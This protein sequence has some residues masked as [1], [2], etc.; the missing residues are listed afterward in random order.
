MGTW[1][2]IFVRDRSYFPA[3]RLL[4]WPKFW[5]FQVFPQGFPLLLSSRVTNLDVYDHLWYLTMYFGDR[6]TMETSLMGAEGSDRAPESC[7]DFGSLVDLL[8]VGPGS[9]V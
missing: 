3:P 7:F 2:G 8:L 1:D 6:C 4:S 9:G 5:I